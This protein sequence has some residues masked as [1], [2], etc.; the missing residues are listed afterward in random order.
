MLERQHLY[1]RFCRVTTGNAARP[2]EW[3]DNQQ[4]RSPAAMRGSRTANKY[5]SKSKQI[6]FLLIIQPERTA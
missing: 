6:L 1:R 5:I 2:Y 4:R 3:N